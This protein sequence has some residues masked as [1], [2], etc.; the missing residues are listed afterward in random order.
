MLLVPF[1]NLRKVLVPSFCSR[2][3]QR[4][5][6]EEGLISPVLTSPWEGQLGTQNLRSM[7]MQLCQTGTVPAPA[8]MRSPLG[9]ELQPRHLHHPPGR[10]VQEG[11][12][13]AGGQ[14]LVS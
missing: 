1:P 7:H 9:V 12:Q 3:S 6:E 11:A 2:T 14:V 8:D 4:T 13:R 10:L 5:E